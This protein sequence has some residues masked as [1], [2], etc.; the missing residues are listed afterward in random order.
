MLPGT[1]ARTAL[2]FAEALRHNVRALGISHDASAVDDCVTVSCG[3]AT[4]GAERDYTAPEIIQ[5]ADFALYTAKKRGRD[6][7]EQQTRLDF[8]NGMDLVS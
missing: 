3:V 2:E 8:E 1:E 7:V 6:R 4:V 5:A